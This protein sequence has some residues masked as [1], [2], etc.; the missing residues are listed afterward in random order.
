MSAWFYY[1]KELARLS[2]PDAV[3]MFYRV[4]CK[5]EPVE[6]FLLISREGKS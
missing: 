1:D 5:T 6:I 4:F 3:D 2:Y